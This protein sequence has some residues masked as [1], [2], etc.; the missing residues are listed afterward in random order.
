[1]RPGRGVVGRV[2]GVLVAVGSGTLLREL[3]L[4]SA[5]EGRLFIATDEGDV[6][7]VDL[8]ETMGAGVEDSAAVNAH[9]PFLS[10]WIAEVGKHATDT[11]PPKYGAYYGFDHATP[12]NAEMVAMYLF[13]YR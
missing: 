3:G 11:L 13:S 2:G 8:A 9:T 6:A 5:T 10:H 7:S 12:K 1:M 4:P